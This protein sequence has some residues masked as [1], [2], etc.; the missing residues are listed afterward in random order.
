MSGAQNRGF[1]GIVVPKIALLHHKVEFS[2]AKVGYFEYFMRMVDDTDRRLLRLMQNN[3]DMGTPELAK[4]AGLPAASCWRR[5]EKMESAGVVRGKRI[6]VVPKAL[7]YE[8]EVSLRISLDKTQ[9]N[10]FDQF[11][12]RA[13]DIP[14]INEIQTFLGRVDVRLN[15]LARDMNHYQEIYR[16]RILA[17]PHIDDIE[18]LMLVANVKKSET[19]PL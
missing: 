8:V 18:A 10:A 17:L 16:S 15:V 13:R 7:G 4:L 19:L 11:I 3:P 2:F 6:Q 14:E 1:R 9:S 12:A 5:I